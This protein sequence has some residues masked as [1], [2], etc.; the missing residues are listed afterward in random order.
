LLGVDLARLLHGESVGGR[1]AFAELSGN[2]VS[3]G[4]ETQLRQVHLRAGPVLASG[5]AD[6]DASKNISGRFAAEFNSPAAQA[7]AHF[8]VSGTLREPRFNR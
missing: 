3:E 7:S 6:A 4:G 8:A 5:N 1:T 2:F